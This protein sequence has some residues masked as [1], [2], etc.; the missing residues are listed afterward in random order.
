MP[1]R[2]PAPR[3]A[4]DALLGGRYRLVAP[5]ARGGMAEVWEA[6]DEVLAR[7]VAVKLLLP[8][9]AADPEIVDRFRREAR[10]A[11][12]LSHPNVVAVYDTCDDGEHH[13]IV[14]ELVRGES[15]RQLLDR[16]GPL[17]PARAVAIAASV[18]EALD[19]AH[20]AGLVHRD[21]KPG[22]ILL[23]DDGRVL[24][25][26]F[27]IAKAAVHEGTELTDASVLLGT[28]RYLA[29]EQVRSEP[30]DAR[31]DLY[32]LGVVLYEMLCGVPPFEADTAVATAGMRLHTDPLRPRQ[33]RA[34]IPRRL[35]QL[36]LS[37]MAPDPADRPVD[38]A[39]F[40]ADLRALD[41]AAEPATAA[42]PVTP[43]GGQPPTFVQSERSWL[44]P[45]VLIVVIAGALLMGATV[46]GGTDV[47]RDLF[48]A[49]RDV[50]TGGRPPASEPVAVAGIRAH[51]PL[52]DGREHDD[53]LPNLLD[54]DPGT[55][56]HTERYSSRDLGGLKEGVGF[57]LILAEPV[58]LA[59]LHV[60]AESSGWAAR[61]HVADEPRP[62]VDGWGA[63]VAEASGIGATHTFDLGGATGRAVLVWITDLGDGEPRVRLTGV[64]LTRA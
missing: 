29:P 59:G 49:A 7:P 61:V 16:E 31:A 56:W 17:E 24:V 64:R 26:D 18:A 48:G 38:A 10:S 27:G 39:H 23:T 42:V 28:A 20:R 58:A 54:G 57:V 21:V 60:E 3:A 50:V 4:V 15:L 43:P 44:V 34:G 11:A 9:L 41:V 47:G 1:E 12:R 19:H 35:E 36:V 63:P 45:A 22:N 8:H 13:A 32:A 5:L 6:R 62:G 40:A 2:T 30:V 52:G 14:M 46:L 25:A 51:D 37:A 33:H 53:L 55:A